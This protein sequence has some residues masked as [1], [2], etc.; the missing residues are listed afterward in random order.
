MF[1]ANNKE[2]L[3]EPH[4]PTTLPGPLHA[5]V[6]FLPLSVT[7]SISSWAGCI[8]HASFS[9]QRANSA[10]CVLCTCLCK[11]LH[12]K[13]APWYQKQLSAVHFDS[14]SVANI[15]LGGLCNCFP[16]Y[17]SS[18]HLFLNITFYCANQSIIFLGT[19]KKVWSNIQAQWLPF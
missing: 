6:H 9:A 4:V 12:R 8:I 11:L 5:L 10:E 18:L 13:T 19:Y 17:E 3:E 2:T 14:I 7:I 16:S 15:S 1:E